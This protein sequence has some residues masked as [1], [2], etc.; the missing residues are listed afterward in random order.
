MGI[1][2][3]SNRFEAAEILVEPSVS[4]GR[5]G[6]GGVGQGGEMCSPLASG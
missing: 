4:K 1:T 5:V 6:S 2:S 3:L